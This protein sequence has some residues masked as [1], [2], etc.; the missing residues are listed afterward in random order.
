MA[1]S[2]IKCIDDL[3]GTRRIEMFN[4][5]FG[6]T[7]EGEDIPPNPPRG[8]TNLFDDAEDVGIYVDHLPYLWAQQ[9]HKR[10][11]APR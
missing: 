11:Q 9:S 7:A 5:L 10:S 3:A 6:T 8:R 2:G 4:N 1:N